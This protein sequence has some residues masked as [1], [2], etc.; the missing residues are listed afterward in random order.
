M[1][2]LL[3]D[4]D[5]DCLEDLVAAL[6]PAGHQCDRYSS[7][8]EAVE[9][10]AGKEYDLVVTDMKMPVMTGIGVLQ[11]VRALNRQARVI[12]NTGYGDVE[13]TVAAINHGAY[14]FFGKPLKL[15][16]FME[17]LEKIE[18]EIGEQQKK[19][20][21]HARLTLEYARLKQAYEDLQNLLK[22]GSNA[23]K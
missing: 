4:D 19:V 6:E 7:P 2:I 9:A 16:E 3:I 23:D 8:V 5:S 18:A 22:A 1:K 14:A 13:T 11:K 20:E 12:I 10:Y 21:D 17:V 15:D